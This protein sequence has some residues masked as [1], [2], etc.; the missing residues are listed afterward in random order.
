MLVHRPVLIFLGATVF[1]GSLCYFTAI[2][3][4][5]SDGRTYGMFLFCGALLTYFSVS[6][7]KNFLWLRALRKTSIARWSPPLDSVP[8][9]KSEQ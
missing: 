5:W 2:G 3:M 7:C 6:Q 4:G 1:L 9:R 8:P